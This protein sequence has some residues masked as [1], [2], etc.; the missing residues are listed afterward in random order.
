MVK[1]IEISIEITEAIITNSTIKYIYDKESDKTRYER[2][3]IRN[4]SLCYAPF[5]LRHSNIVTF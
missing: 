4:K 2:N 3:L 1:K 5:S